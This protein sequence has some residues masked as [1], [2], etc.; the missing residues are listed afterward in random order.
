MALSAP[1]DAVEETRRYRI[2][3]VGGAGW[4]GRYYL[5]AAARH[6]RCELVAL[7]DSSRERRAPFAEHYRVRAVYDRLEELLRRETPDIVI[8]CLPVSATPDAV[9]ACAEAGVRAVQCEKPMAESLVQAD[10]MI[11]ACRARGVPFGCGTALYELPHLEEIC[12]LAQN[13]IIGELRD[14]AIPQGFRDQ[15]SGLGCVPLCMLQFVTGRSVEWVEGWTLPDEAAMGDDDCQAYGTLGLQGGLRCTVVSPTEV[16]HPETQVSLVGSEGRIW[17]AP[18]E[19][20]TV[21]GLGADSGPVPRKRQEGEAAE[22]GPG[23]LDGAFGWVIDGLIAA[24]EGGGEPACSA[25]AYRHALEV[26]VALKVSARQGHRRVP[27]PLVD[28][29][30]RMRPIAYRWLGGDVTGWGILGGTPPEVLD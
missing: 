27:L 17:L 13:G 19:P 4:W 16:K 5:R 7:V 20:L 2:A 1:G 22:Q 24:I 21:R 29:T 8:A 6:P 28:R 30:P 26:A 12:R 23:F 18:P 3:V 14:A 11:D 10:R 9:V 15:A 25:R